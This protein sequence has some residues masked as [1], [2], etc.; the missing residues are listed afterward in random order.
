[1]CILNRLNHAEPYTDHERLPTASLHSDDCVPSYQLDSQRDTLERRARTAEAFRERCLNAYQECLESRTRVRTR[2]APITFN[3]HRL[4]V[5]RQRD[6]KRKTFQYATDFL[7]GNRSTRNTCE[8]SLGYRPTSARGAA[9]QTEQ[10][11]PQVYITSKYDTWYC[12][13]PCVPCVLRSAALCFSCVRM[14][15]EVPR[16]VPWG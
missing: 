10:T 3:Y 9:G 11:I 8:P 4:I 14:K 2:C 1:M 6:V 15:V 7:R 5:R 12:C 13:V 16:M